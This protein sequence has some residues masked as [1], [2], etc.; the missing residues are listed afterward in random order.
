MHTVSDTVLLSGALVD[1]LLHAV[2]LPDYVEQALLDNV[3]CL[4]R[5]LATYRELEA[6]LARLAETR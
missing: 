4:L 3:E 2:A 6:E 5:N 1:T